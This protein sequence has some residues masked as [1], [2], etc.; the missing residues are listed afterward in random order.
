MAH[1]LHTEIEIDAAPATVWTILTDI[2]AY[3]DWNPFITSSVGTV[4][5]GERLVNRLEP[6]GGK[7]LTFKPTVTEVDQGRALEWLGR[8]GLPGVFDGRHRFELVPH[9]DGTRLIQSEYFTGMLV[10]ML[11][12]SLD[13]GTLAGFRAMNVA[14]KT[15][16]EAV[17]IGGTA[18]TP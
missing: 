18:S 8:L 14:L 6:P 4:A 3:P 11:R 10:P 7:P 15:R 9:N 17:A 2:A 5:A 16:A 1:H 13:T 12:R